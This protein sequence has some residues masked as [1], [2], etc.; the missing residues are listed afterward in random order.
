MKN[1]FTKDE[2]ETISVGTIALGGVIRLIALLV[3][4][5]YILAH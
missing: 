2:S 3:V 4:K 1:P 5:F